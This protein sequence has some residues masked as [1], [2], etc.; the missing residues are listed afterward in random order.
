MKCRLASLVQCGDNLDSATKKTEQIETRVFSSKAG[1]R[2]EQF[3]L[4]LL[5]MCVLQKPKRCVQ[6]Y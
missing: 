5:E 4:F 6:T 2:S 1:Y 3:S